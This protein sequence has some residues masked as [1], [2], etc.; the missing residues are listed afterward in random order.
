MNLLS[1]FRASYILCVLFTSTFSYAEEKLSV[2]KK[3]KEG[4]LWF[5]KGDDG[6]TKFS[7][8]MIL[9]AKID[10]IV[11]VVAANEKH[12]KDAVKL[13][14]KMRNAL[15]KYENTPDHIPVV[16]FKDEKP[17]VHYRFYSDGMYSGSR[18]SLGIFGPAEAKNHLRK[19][20]ILHQLLKR[21][22]AEGEWGQ[23]DAQETALQIIN[24]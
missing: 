18:E 14:I 2:F 12:I 6:E 24:Q 13:A 17:G 16:A 4:V 19:V 7:A 10:G 8:A 11:V 1:I 3:D 5:E 20:V 21:R 23:D 22:V 9:S 15:Q